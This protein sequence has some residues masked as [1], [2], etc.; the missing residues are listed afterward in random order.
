MV[1]IDCHELTVD[2]QLALAGSLSESFQGK[3]VALVN[4][5]K[6]VFDTIEGPPPDEDRIERL[7][8]DFISR[9]KD[10]KYYSIE[11]VGQA[12]VVHSADPLARERGR[13]QAGLPDNVLKCPFCAFVTPYQEAYNVHFRSHLFGV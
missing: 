7:V 4:G 10:S 8:S 9:R 12:L 11:R 5:D 2:E 13:K 1:D 6:V 3:V